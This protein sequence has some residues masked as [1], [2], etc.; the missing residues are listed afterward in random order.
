V[1]EFMRIAK[2]NAQV[3]LCMARYAS[4]IAADLHE[5]LETGP[6][7]RCQIHF[8]DRRNKVPDSPTG[9]VHARRVV[10]HNIVP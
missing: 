7:R 1:G 5:A 6:R 10:G 3:E 4:R 8:T 9:R 2:A